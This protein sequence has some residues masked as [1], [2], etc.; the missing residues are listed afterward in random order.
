LAFGLSIDANSGGGRPR[1]Q[2]TEVHSG[3]EPLRRSAIGEHQRRH[4]GRTHLDD[5]WR[6]LPAGGATNI[7]AFVARIGTSLQA[8][9]L[10]NSTPAGVAKL[11]DLTNK[12]LIRH[13]HT[14][15]TRAR[16]AVAASTS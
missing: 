5:R 9:V 8:T 2:G 1:P 13:P 7:P 12:G 14:M 6:I 16:W 11:K 3:Q 4:A 10:I 15:T